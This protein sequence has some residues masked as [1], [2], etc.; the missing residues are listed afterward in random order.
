MMLKRYTLE[1][2]KAM[3]EPGCYWYLATPYSHPDPDVMEMRADA[4]SWWVKELILAGLIPFSTIHYNHSIAAAGQLPT[5]HEYWLEFNRAFL[6]NCN[7]VLI[8]WIKGWDTSKGI[9][10]E[11]NY[12]KMTLGK[13]VYVVS[14]GHGNPR[15]FSFK[16]I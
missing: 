2:V 11:I 4:A 8:P 9:A 3:H 15:E 10:Q 16:K 5:D 13:T 7:G 6:D 1:E 12:A 14:G